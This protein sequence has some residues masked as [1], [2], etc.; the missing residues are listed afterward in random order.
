MVTRVIAAF[1]F[2]PIFL[3]ILFFCPPPA[4]AATLGCITAVIA[5]ELLEAQ[6]VP[7]DSWH[8]PLIVVSAFSM[9][10][11]LVA[12]ANMAVLGMAILVLLG[13]FLCAIS[14]YGTPREFSFD[15][16]GLCFFAGV[17]FPLCLGCIVPLRLMDRGEFFALLPVGA[18]F[19]T[20]S[21]AYFAGVTL[22]KHRG[23]T[24]VSPN[25]SLEGYV[26]G[27]LFCMVI[28]LLYGYLIRHFA[29]FSVDFPRL[30]LYALVG[31]LV[32]ELGDLSF[33]LIKRQKGVKDFGDL[34]PGHGGMLDRFD[35]MIFS[36]PVMYALVRL[37]PAFETGLTRI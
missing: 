34:I 33:S 18:A 17:I 6:G 5:T 4:L 10:I 37:L 1:V 8:R 12:Y 35:S 9:P 21:G 28:F 11:L 2:G 30:G 31:A 7:K 36:A 23:I 3:G 19:A 29:G 26:G 32:T 20:D 16:I 22:G 14:S 24:K 15:T 27:V 25:K 13:L